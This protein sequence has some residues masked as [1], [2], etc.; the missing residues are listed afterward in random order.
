MAQLLQFI[1]IWPVLDRELILNGFETSFGR[2]E[3][4][5][6]QLTVSVTQLTVYLI[7][8]AIDG[9]KLRTYRGE[10]FRLDRCIEYT[11]SIENLTNVSETRIP[12]TLDVSKTGTTS[13]AIYSS[14]SPA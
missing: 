8:G 13:W 14:P 4:V 2:E 5:C 6:W 11:C 9:V 1:D 3:A 10:N 12:S 7:D